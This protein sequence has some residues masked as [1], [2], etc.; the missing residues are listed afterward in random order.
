MAVTVQDPTV[1]SWT[2]INMWAMLRALINNNCPLLTNNGIPT[3]GTTGTFAGQAGPGSLLIDFANGDLYINNGTLASPLWSPFSDS[4]PVAL[5]ANGAINPHLP[6]NYI[7][8]KTG[9]LAAMTLAAPTAGADDGTVI[10]ITSDTVFAHTITCPA[11]VFKTGGVAVTVF[12]FTGTTSGG[13]LNLLAYN[14]TWK[15]LSFTGGAFA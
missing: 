13:G 6:K 8:T 3:D 15:V 12:T 14:G 1:A 5:S 7:I 2:P 10:S 9:S 11:A 4:M